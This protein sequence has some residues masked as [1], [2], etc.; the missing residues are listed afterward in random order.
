MATKTLGTSATTSLTAVLFSYAP[1]TLSDADLATVCQAIRSQDNVAHP[2]AQQIGVG[3]FSREGILYLPDNRGSI[4][5][6]PG[7][8]IAVD[9]NS[10]S[11]WPIVIPANA[12]TNGPWTHS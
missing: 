3:G 12:I 10:S 9:T 6:R 7:D 2:R 8:Y 4:I 11:G 5:V 1:A